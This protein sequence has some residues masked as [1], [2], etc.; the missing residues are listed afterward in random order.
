MQLRKTVPGKNQKP[1][2]YI[3]PA[4]VL[5]QL[6][7]WVYFTIPYVSSFKTRAKSLICV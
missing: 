2:K 5:G 3:I 1:L 7:F 6:N 4:L